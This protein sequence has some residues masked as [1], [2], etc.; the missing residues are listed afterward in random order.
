MKMEE[1]EEERS[2]LG[3]FAVKVRGV[4]PSIKTDGL[5]VVVGEMLNNLERR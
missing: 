4:G 1:E 3:W 2:G 5:N